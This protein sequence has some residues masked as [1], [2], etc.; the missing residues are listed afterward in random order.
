MVNHV[1]IWDARIS[2]IG[3]S[4]RLAAGGPGGRSKHS[5]QYRRASRGIVLPIAIACPLPLPCSELTAMYAWAV[6]LPMGLP[7]PA[8]FPLG[9]LLHATMPGV[10]CASK[11]ARPLS[12]WQSSP[13]PVTGTRGV[14]VQ[15]DS[16]SR[17]GPAS[18]MVW[19]HISYDIP[20]D[21]QIYPTIAWYIPPLWYG[22]VI[23][24]SI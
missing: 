3:H 1:R 2:D 15:L 21:Y 17:S 22:S 20:H 14:P 6:S 4:L 7:P 12:L 11:L 10:R 23:Y 13:G 18:G 16:G 19:H 9:R 8:I 5:I 24:I